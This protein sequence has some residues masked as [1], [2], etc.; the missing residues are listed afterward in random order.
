MA[1]PS[2]P[3]TEGVFGNLSDLIP[4]ETF[5]V[6]GQNFQVYTN[7]LEMNPFVLLEEHVIAIATATESAPIEHEL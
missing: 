2:S 4:I 3:S 7:E 5:Y 6:S 1:R